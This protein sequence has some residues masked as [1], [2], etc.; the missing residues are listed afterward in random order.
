MARLYTNDGE[1]KSSTCRL[2]SK[3]SINLCLMFICNFGSTTHFH[4]K[5][6]TLNSSMEERPTRELNFVSSIPAGSTPFAKLEITNL[7]WNLWEWVVLNS[8]RSEIYP[9]SHRITGT[10]HCTRIIESTYRLGILQR[11]VVVSFKN[12]ILANPH[13]MDLGIKWDWR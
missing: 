12:M 5:I 9:P 13:I 3:R 6:V 7:Q 8:R 1:I 10:R 11:K 4:I 2:Y